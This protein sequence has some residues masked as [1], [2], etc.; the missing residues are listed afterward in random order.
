[1]GC[2][3]PKSKFADERVKEV[4]EVRERAENLEKD[5]TSVIDSMDQTDAA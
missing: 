4:K 5:L 3:G 2:Y 1:M